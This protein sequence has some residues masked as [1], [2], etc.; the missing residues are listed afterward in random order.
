VN[1]LN[2]SSDLLLSIY[3]SVLPERSAVYCSAP[4]TSGRRYLEWIRGFGGR[5]S[6]VDHAATSYRH[7]HSAAVVLPN[8]V[9][10]RRVIEQLRTDFACPFIDPTSVPQIS[11]WKQADWLN[12]WE[13]VIQRYTL[14]AVFLDDWQYS[15]GCSHEFAFAI[16]L[17]LRTFDE[18]GVPLDGETGAALIRSAIAAIEEV[19]SPVGGL[20]STLQHLEIPARGA[21]RPL[22]TSLSEFLSAKADALQG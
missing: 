12:F 20:P 8:M 18:R 19:G 21:A 14:A 9:R 15:Y 22:R 11:H 10:A 4:I 16:Q 7:E 1:T 17:G 6:D 13:A 2:V 3:A 5:V